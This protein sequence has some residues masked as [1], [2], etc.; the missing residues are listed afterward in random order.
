MLKIK[1]TGLESEYEIIGHRW[2]PSNGNIYIYKSLEDDGLW[3][4]NYASTAHQTLKE[5]KDFAFEILEAD[6]LVA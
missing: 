1:R 6:G 3:F 2:H 4:F 5:A